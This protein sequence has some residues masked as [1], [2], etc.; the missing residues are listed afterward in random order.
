MGNILVDI[1]EA[2]SGQFSLTIV[3]PGGAQIKDRNPG[4]SITL[5]EHEHRD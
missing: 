4:Q 2:S 5:Q 1:D 3:V